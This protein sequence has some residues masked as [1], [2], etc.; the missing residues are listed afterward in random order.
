MNDLINGTYRSLMTLDVVYN[1][2]DMAGHEAPKGVEADRRFHMWKATTAA[3]VVESLKSVDGKEY[4]ERIEN[5]N[6]NMSQQILDAI[7]SFVRGSDEAILVNLRNI[8][9]SSIALDKEI[10][11]LTARIDW[12]LPP[13]E[14]RLLFNPA[15]MEVEIGSVMPRSGQI[16]DVAIAPML[17]KRGKSTGEGFDVGNLL[18]KMEVACIPS[19]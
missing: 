12:L 2:N 11:K 5:F 10:S 3:L 4:R 16:V 19:R 14:S 15:C 8:I 13:C 6:S 18:L 1:Y 17:E 9:E 7:Q